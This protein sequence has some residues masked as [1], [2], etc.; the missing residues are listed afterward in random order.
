MVEVRVKFPCQ[1]SIYLTVASYI[2][3]TEHTQVPDALH[4]VVKLAP[5]LKLALS[6]VLILMRRRYKQRHVVPVG[7]V[8]DLALVGTGTVLV[9]LLT[10]VYLLCTIV[11]ASR[12]A[13]DHVA[14]KYLSNV[15]MPF[16]GSHQNYFK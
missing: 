16:F 2:E 14:V 3:S 1:A 11:R 5:V 13:R 7:N 4:K 9:V 8:R 12:C 6:L 10:F 15:T